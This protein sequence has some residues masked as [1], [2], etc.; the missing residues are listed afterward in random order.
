[1]S[2]LKQRLLSSVENHGKCDI[3]GI[4]K[5]YPRERKFTIIRNLFLL[6]NDGWV[7]ISKYRVID[8]VKTNNPNVRRSQKQMF[9]NLSLFDSL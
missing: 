5:L 7:I 1:M 8:G 9:K 6:R 3:Y 2:K 4:L